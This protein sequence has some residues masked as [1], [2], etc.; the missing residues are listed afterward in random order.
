[1]KPEGF[2]E[3]VIKSPQVTRCFNS[4]Q[5]STFYRPTLSPSTGNNSLM[6]ENTW[7]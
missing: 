2:N 5:E 4:E 6:M 1:L 7:T 3:K